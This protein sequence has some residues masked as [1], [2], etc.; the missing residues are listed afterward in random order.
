M[1]II[2]L[3]TD[4]GLKDHYVSAIK[5]A[6]LG[7]LPG[8]TIIDISHQIEKYN[9]LEASFILKESYPNF[10]AGT[11]HLIGINTE[12][13][14]SGGYVLV[15]QYDHYFIG[16]D[17]GIFSLLFEETPQNIREISPEKGE[18]LSFPVRD[19]FTKIAYDLAS[20]K[21][22]D[23][24]GKPKEAL[25]QRIPFRATSMGDN[26]RGSF[27]Y[28]DSYDNVTSN[29]ERRLFDQVGKGRPFIIELARH[30]IERISTEYSEVPE[31]E[32]LA[33]FN[34][35]DHLEIAMRNGKAGSL[36]NLKINDSITIRFQ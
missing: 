11:I 26:I 24:I 21:D 16:A 29:I 31:G 27:V 35:S 17:N 2:T 18:K 15:K 20:G 14:G 25:L 4:F 23:Q 6:I 32:V 36:L 30:T 19:I 12:L 1:A 9:L 7:R 10:P 28:I 3:T 34:S 13:A 5:G 22:F 8:A 33:I